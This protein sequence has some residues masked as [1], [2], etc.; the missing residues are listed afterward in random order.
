MDTINIYYT[1]TI[2][3]LLQSTIIFNNNYY[4]RI[5]I[6]FHLLILLLEYFHGI[7]YE[8]TK[9]ERSEFTCKLNRI[10]GS[11]I[12]LHTLKGR[13]KLN[14]IWTWVAVKIQICFVTY[15]LC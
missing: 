8:N 14:E 9:R 4:L 13:I 3:L 7:F 1:T 6:E 5:F 12:I 11:H 10:N 15:R 2:L